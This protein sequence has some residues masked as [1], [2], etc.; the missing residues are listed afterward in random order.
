MGANVIT[1]LVFNFQVDIVIKSFSLVLASFKAVM[2][3]SV[4]YRIF[5]P[6]K[7]ALPLINAPFGGYFKLDISVIVFSTPLKNSTVYSNSL[8]FINIVF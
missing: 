6:A 1:L 5:S 4:P 7:L 8:K 2:L 3:L